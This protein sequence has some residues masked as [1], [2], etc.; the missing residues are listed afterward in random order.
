MQNKTFKILSIDFDFFAD[1]TQKELMHYPDGID[2]PTDLTCIIWASHYMTHGDILN[3]ININKKLYKDLIYLLNCQKLHTPTL[4]TNSHI[5]A[6]NF[7]EQNFNNKQ[8][9]LTHIDWHHDMINE[10]RKMDCGNWISFLKKKHPDT[11]VK[12]VTREESV[13]C[14][15]LT[16]EEIKQA[17]VKFNFKEFEYT[18]FDAIFLCRSDSWTP[19][20]LDKYFNKLVNICADLIFD[21]KIEECVKKPRDLSE[22]FRTINDAQ[23]INAE[24]QKHDNNNRRKIYNCE[25]T[26]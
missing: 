14:Y 26:R 25:N 10:N 16:S 19:P 17:D 7:I 11:I 1:V 18:Q 5:H 12:W 20:H 15:G 9:E 21:I 3:S 6:F 8:I 13:K 24:R 2:Y 4:I 22:I 23:Y